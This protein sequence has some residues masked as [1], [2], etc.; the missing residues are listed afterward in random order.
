VKIGG[1]YGGTPG[2]KRFSKKWQKGKLPT[3]LVRSIAKQL[4]KQWNI[5]VTSSKSDT[6]IVPQKGTAKKIRLN[7]QTR[8]VLIGNAFINAIPDTGSTAS[9]LTEGSVKIL[10]ENYTRE[11]C[12]R[13]RWKIFTVPPY[14]VA[15]AD[16]STTISKK[17]VGATLIVVTP[18]GRCNLTGVVLNV[19]PGPAQKLLIGRPE[20]RRMGIP[21]MWSLIDEAIKNGTKGKQT[22]VALQTVE[23][24]NWKKRRQEH[25]KDEP[26]CIQAVDQIYGHGGAEPTKK[27]TFDS[28]RDILTRA[29]K[30]GA[31]V[32][33][34]KKLEHLVFVVHKDTWRLMLGKD[35]PARME[36]MV[37]QF[38]EEKFP[39]NIQPRK[40]SPE[41]K[42]FCGTEYP[43]C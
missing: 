11:A 12:K 40:Y 14:T 41:Q 18:F 43:S 19:I 27:Y 20:L 4:T 35:P 2:C 29:K 39:R 7:K 38:T 16:G 30:S 28:M 31:S 15:L 23:L 34:L 22:E 9:V 32:S 21:T 17:R 13:A 24:D 10:E 42:I 6:A 25:E 5:G 1:D 3:P 33:F 37:I 8:G 36:P 26:D